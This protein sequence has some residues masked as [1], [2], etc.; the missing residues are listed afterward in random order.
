MCR[1]FMWGWLGRFIAT[2]ALGLKLK[3]VQITEAIF[4]HLFRSGTNAAR[5]FQLNFKHWAL[6]FM[7]NVD[8]AKQFLLAAIDA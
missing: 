7:E 3:I 6:I 8:R 4:S 5:E 1:M 2:Y